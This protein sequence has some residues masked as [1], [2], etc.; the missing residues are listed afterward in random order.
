M[1][2]GFYLSLLP[3]KNDVS[4]DK[5]ELISDIYLGKFVLKLAPLSTSHI[6]TRMVLQMEETCLLNYST[7]YLYQL[8]S[9]FANELDLFSF[10]LIFITFIFYLLCIWVCFLLRNF[11]DI[12]DELIVKLQLIS[13][14]TII[15]SWC[16]I[17][18]IYTHIFLWSIYCILNAYKTCIFL[19]QTTILVFSLFILSAS[20]NLVFARQGQYRRCFDA[21]LTQPDRHA[22]SPKEYLKFR[23]H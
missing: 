8:F 13:S 14:E 16:K 2:W 4:C 6:S 23:F 11:L 20:K 19:R 9:D 17:F 10:G 5:L 7:G 21:S 12:Y 15:W 3:L 1:L 22:L 18:H